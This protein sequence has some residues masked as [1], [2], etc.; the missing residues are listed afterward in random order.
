MKSYLFIVGALIVVISSLITL[1]IFFQQSLQLEIAEQFNK[2]Q[3]LL[4]KSAAFDMETCFNNQK[5]EMLSFA[6][7][8]SD[9][10]GND[11]KKLKNKLDEYFSRKPNF[12]AEVAIFNNKGEMI[13]SWQNDPSEI[14]G[15]DYIKNT[16]NLSSGQAIV[17]NDTYRVYMATPIYSRG[18][19]EG[20][21]LFKTP[22]S[23]VADRFFSPVM[24]DRAS[25]A[26][27]MDKDGTLLYHPGY[28]EMVGGNVYKA[29]SKCFECHIS[30]DLEKRIIEGR[31]SDYGRHIAPT[32]EDKI[33]AFS[34][35]N[36]DNISWIVAVSSPY[37][38]VTHATKRSMNIYSY[39]II[40]IFITASVVSGILIVLNKKRIQAEEIAKREQELEKY[41]LMLESKV[42]ERTDE[43]ASEK[44]KLN[45]IVSAI[46]GGI[47]LIDKNAKIQWA[48]QMIKDMVGMDVVGKYCE[49]LWAD[50]DISASHVKDDIETI[51]L[52]TFL[53]QKDR[54]FQI[55]TAP[56]KGEDAEVHGYIRLIQDV[57]EMKK[58]EEQIMQS[59]K[60]ASIGRLAA[61]IAHEIGNPLT[62]I[63][64][65]IQI[66]RE[67]EEDEFKK[68]SLQTIYF[69]I[70][71]ISEILKQLSG[72]TKM[73][74]VE[75][76]ECR[77]N[78]T[79]ETSINLIQYDKRAKNIFIKKELLPSLLPDIVM[80]CNQL[81]Q[82]FVNLILNAIDAM[83]D[84]GTLTVRSLIKGDD[85][86]IQFEDNGTGIPKEDLT[87]IFDPFY[88]TKEKGT[89]LGL[90]VSYN[91]IK[92]L[93]GTLTVE[94]EEGKGTIFTITLPIK[95]S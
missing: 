57:T 66:L 55:T 33:I 88:T 44:E 73:P 36:M 2:Q 15:L 53:G 65:F 6:L 4:A 40:S 22:I 14:S 10:I 12:K 92:K 71:R 19:L 46:G 25:D 1:N 51:I 43:L 78:E 18:V 31:A 79:I 67:V 3:L 37:S 82:V 42:K 93:N 20:A 83:P 68:E 29:D 63:F 9:L 13:Y 30:F 58:M 49:E 41:A 81:S 52:S 80:D 28:P 39:L 76:R 72:F 85:I 90:A 7:M 34:A 16:F 27:M 17:G 59:E 86:V 89:G 45:S 84:G 61:G 77:I 26:W 62:S 54:F 35:V 91:I 74:A 50:C 60:L 87:R 48:N 5:E 94:S 70:N 38:A 32:G 47:L 11:E 95:S 56:V 64:S 8:M 23:A 69:H 24:S 75:S 21:V